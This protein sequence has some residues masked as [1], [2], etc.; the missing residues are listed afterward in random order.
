MAWDKGFNFRKVD[1]HVTDGTDETYVRG[2]GDAYPVTRNSCTFGWESG[3]IDRDDLTGASDRRFAGRNYSSSAAQAV[4]RVDLPNT[5][6]FKVR[7]A[8]GDHS[9]AQ[10]NQY[11]QIDDTTT[12]LFHVE[13]TD[14]IS[15]AHYNDASGVDRAEANWAADNVGV[16]GTFSTT[17]FR[18]RLAK[19][20]VFG[21]AHVIAHIFISEQAGGGGGISIP[22]VQ[23]YRRMMQMR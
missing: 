20:T 1:T 17:I 2:A 6:T 12:E 16:D 8:N 14:A 22:V 13:D 11:L 4:F 21:S 19:T 9:R 18:C 5:G 23:G 3:T 7:V 15:A 10:G